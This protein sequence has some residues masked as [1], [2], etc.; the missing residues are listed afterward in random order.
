MTF[1]NGTAWVTDP[2]VAPSTPA[3]RSSSKRRLPILTV[4][5]G[6]LLFVPALAWSASPAP[7]DIDNAASGPTVSVTGSGAPG[8][9][10]IIDG[11]GF[12]AHAVYQVH[13]DSVPRAIRLVWPSVKGTFHGHLRIPGTATSG[14]H[15]ATFSRVDRTSAVRVVAGTLARSALPHTPAVT[16]V[17]VRVTRKNP[18]RTTPPSISLVKATSVSDTAALVTWRLDEPAT[19]QVDYGTTTAYGQETA[20]EKSLQYTAHAQKVSGLAP[21][22]QYHYRVRSQDAGG[23]LS[24]STDFTFTTMPSG[25]DPTATPDPTATASPDPT[26]T[27]D[28][29]ATTDPTATPDPT[30]K[31]TATPGATQTPDPTTT[32]QPGSGGIYGAAFNFDTK[33]N[34][35]VGWTDRAKVA[36][37]F[38]ASTTSA[39]KSVRFQQRGGPIYSG[40][41]GGTYRITVQTDASG[42]PSGTVLA[43]ATYS[44]G[45]PS[46]AWTTYDAVTFP[47]PATLTKG[48]RY[49][50]V[51][52]N[53]DANPV[54]NYFSVNELFVY[55]STL[56]PRQPAFA[57]A[58]YAVL[59]AAPSSWS[60]EG[61]YTA[62]MDLA[63]SNGVHDGMAYIANIVELYGTISGSA[64]VREHFTVS[65]GDRTISKAFVRVRR[66]SGSSPLT[67]RLETGSGTLIDSANVAASSVPASA[68]GGDN[69]GSVW[70]GVTFGSAHTL[71]NGTSYNL[72][73][74]TPSGTEYTAAPI[75][76][77]TD[78]GLMSTAFR[79]GS[80]QSSGNGTTWADLYQ[81]S[82]VDIQFYFR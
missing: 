81:Y 49:Y 57:D 15:S 37:R 23:R 13:W 58:D 27:P 18:G 31:P 16:T 64:S 26:G 70:V 11:R 50:I 62:D 48:S 75:R 67:I 80:G 32:P 60:V 71:V 43:A 7:D 25:A 69:G 46:G 78:V 8:Q 3:R 4:A 74:T 1:W 10:V 51:F 9:T 41:N 72:R 52:E 22:T 61:R 59:T 29:T 45:N 55:G 33:A 6:L 47:S 79:D 5:I 17:N 73:L 12:K 76:E 77:G 19:G 54:G 56:T 24:V 53:I 2:A 20:P 38:V 82:P 28:P 35:Q 68:A 65:G 40:G 14:V 30:A 34:L 21:G 44:P 39:L 66:T 42:V 63:Y 36:H